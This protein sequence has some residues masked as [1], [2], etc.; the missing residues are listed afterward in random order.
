MMRFKIS[1]AWVAAIAALAFASI[2]SRGDDPPILRYVIAI[3]AGSALVSVLLWRAD[4]ASAFWVLAG[5]LLLHL[6]A[7][8]GVPAFEDDHYR[9][10]WD[11][12]L[13]DCDIRHALWHAA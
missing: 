10:I 1:G 11:G 9:F 2:L 6:V 4:R 7:L 5:A 8:F 12:W 13:A 3:A